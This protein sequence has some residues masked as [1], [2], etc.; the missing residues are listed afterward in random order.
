VLLLESALS[1]PVQMFLANRMGKVSPPLAQALTAADGTFALG[2]RRVGNL[3]DLRI[4]S[5]D[6]P[7]QSLQQIRV[8][9]H[10]WFDA[11]DLVLEAGVPVS[12]RVIETHS[13][14]PV[15]DATVYLAS[16]HQSHAMTATPGR[17]RGVPM[18]TGPDG[19]FRCANGP[20][21]GLVNLVAEAKGFATAQILNQQLKPDGT[22]DFTLELELGQPIAGMVVDAAGAPV[23]D[24]TVNANGL[25]SKTPQAGS[26]IT[27]N[28]G[29][30]QFPS[31][32][33]GPYQLTTSSPR[34]AEAKVPLVMA[35]E[36]EV[37]VVLA[38]RGSVLLKVL[39]ANGQAVKSYRLSLK[40]CFPNNPL[41]IGNV[42]D[43]PDRAITPADYRDHGGFA[44]V[45]GMPAGDFTFQIIDQAHAKTLSPAFTIVEGGP[46]VEVVATLTLGGVI[47]GTVVDDRGAPIAG[48]VVTTDMNGGI[49]DN[50]LGEIFRNLMPEKHTSATARTD[51]QGRFRLTRLAFAAYMLRASHPSYC[52]GNA[53]DLKLENEGQVVDAGVIQL[54]LGAVI[55]GITQVGGEPAGQ[56]KVTLSTAMTTENLPAAPKDGAPTRP[57]AGPQRGLFHAAVHSDG[58]GRFRLLKRVP[59]GTYRIAASRPASGNNLFESI[60]DM[61]E[62]AQEVTIAPGQE[63]VTLTFHLGRR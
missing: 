21:Q 30:F 14:T 55:E 4:V 51:A 10:D 35:G 58:D 54:P 45:K 44:L 32:R 43:W 60:F 50:P 61:K 18:T 48:A 5:D 46:P 28:D 59:P 41:G 22:N 31:L 19:T 34:H 11:K 24:V 3:V 56:V 40:R 27:A 53:L 25:S 2:L 17:E 12:G 15:A 42:I 38:T 6:H 9:E 23:A 37:K 1:D 7:E 49:G 29:T 57:A 13:G 33:A 16:S 52:E 39:A 8:R 62:S 20:R 36:L 63:T 26:A 47:T